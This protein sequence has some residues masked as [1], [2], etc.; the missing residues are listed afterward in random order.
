MGLSK[1]VYYVETYWSKVLVIAVPMFFFISGILFF[2]TFDIKGLWDK[3]KKRVFTI[4]IPYI[5]WCTLYY[6]YFVLCTNIPAI[7]GLMN[8]VEGE[9]VKLSF[10]EWASWLW[11][12]KYYTLW[13][14]QY[15][16]V[17]IAITPIIWLV[18]KNHTSK[19]PTGLVALVIILVGKQFLPLVI[20]H[21]SGIEVYLVGSYIGLNC[22]EQLKY[23]NK[24]ITLVSCIYIILTLLTAFKYLNVITE[25]LLFIAIWFACDLFSLEGNKY[26]WWMSITFFTYVA[27]D[28]FLQASKKVW[29]RVFGN[30]AIFALLEY[31]FMP[32]IIEALL[33]GIAYIIRST[34]P[35]IWK[36][37]TGDRGTK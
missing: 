8:G 14:L 37:I 24:L 4:L 22:R 2:R 32:L 19:F 15:L 18:L 23:K 28:V 9:T 21:T 25:I 13:F 11:V 16:I 1:I 6:L 7:K 10:G 27:H 26:P 17:F 5:I 33:I 34:L 36:I 30:H 20:P 29:W 12:N 35:V 3:W 31:I